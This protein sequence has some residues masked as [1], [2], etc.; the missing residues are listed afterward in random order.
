MKKLLCAVL[1]L[2]A[3]ITLA[4]AVVWGLFNGIFVAFGERFK[5][6]FKWLNITGTFLLITFLWAFYVWPDTATAVKMVW[7][8]FAEFGFMNFVSG[9]GS[10]N[11]NLGEWL[12]FLGAVLV[13]VWHDVRQ[14]QWNTRYAGMKPETRVAVICALGL[15]VLIFGMYGIG[16][17]AADFIYSQF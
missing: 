14:E 10:L 9:L 13:L 7:S 11:L 12:V 3:L 8:V 17:N 4:T 2:A 16:F 5:T 15:A 1:C 6:R